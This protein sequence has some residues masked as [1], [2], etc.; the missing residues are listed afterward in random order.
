MVSFH[1]VIRLRK[2]GHKNHPIYQV[3]TIARY[4]RNRGSFLTKLGFL[5]LTSKEH[6]FFVN[7]RLL[8]SSMNKGASLNSTVKK[9]ISKFIII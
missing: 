9:Y 1:H 8:G 6:A 4:K 5:N 7:L 2:G 3:I